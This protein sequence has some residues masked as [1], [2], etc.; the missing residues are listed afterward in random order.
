MAINSYAGQSSESCCHIC[1]APTAKGIKHS[2]ISTSATRQN[3]EWESEGEHSKVWTDRIYGGRV[4]I[5]DLEITLIHV[6]DLSSGVKVS[7]P[8]FC[9]PNSSSMTLGTRR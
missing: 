1:G 2:R 9:E 3:L 5:H 8:S 4:G 6:V 7:H